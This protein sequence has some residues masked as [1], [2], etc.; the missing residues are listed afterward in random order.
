MTDAPPKTNPVADAQFIPML[1]DQAE[2]ERYTS[3]LNGMRKFYNWGWQKAAVINHALAT[4]EPKNLSLNKIKAYAGWQEK[5]TRLRDAI[6]E[7]VDDLYPK[8]SVEERRSRV[9]AVVND[10]V[11][12]DRIFEEAHALFGTDEAAQSVVDI[13]ERLSEKK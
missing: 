11:L 13:L 8:I 2:Y 3:T 6:E 9:Y 10:D 5:A 12:M 7:K 1:N 4:R